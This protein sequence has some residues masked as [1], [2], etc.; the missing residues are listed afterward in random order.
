MQI[1]GI[2]RYPSDEH[3]RPFGSGYHLVVAYDA[4]RTK[5]SLIA[6]GSLKVARVAK[7]SLRN[8]EPQDVPPRRL[9][10]RLDAKRKAFKRAGVAIRERTVRQVIAALRDAN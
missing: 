1:D 2:Y 4:G 5:V 8:A 10:R 9:A 7:A 3:D 6:T